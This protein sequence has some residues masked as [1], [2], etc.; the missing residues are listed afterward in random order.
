MLSGLGAAHIFRNAVFRRGE[1]PTGMLGHLKH[2]PG[3][4]IK[5]FAFDYWLKVTRELTHIEHVQTYQRRM[6]GLVGTLIV[7]AG[8][9]IATFISRVVYERVYTVHA[10]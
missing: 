10:A 5:W 1:L 8:I 6:V 2:G 3:A 7:S 4:H 9:G